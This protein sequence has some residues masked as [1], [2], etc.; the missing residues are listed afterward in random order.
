MP[1]IQYG[2]RMLN[3]Q[4]NNDFQISAPQCPT[5][6]TP[7]GNGDVLDIVVHRNVRLSDVTVSDILDSDHLPI[8]FHI[9]DHVSARDILAPVESHTD[10]KRFRS[11]ASDLISLRIQIDTAVDADRAA[12]NFAASI[13]SAYRLSTRK[14]TLLELNNELPE[15]DRFLHLKRGLRKLW[16]V[17]RD[18]SYKTAVRW[19]TK[20]I[21][22]MTWG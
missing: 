18:P 20:T 15:L 19:V 16:H 8:F 10:W 12:C 5:H 9:L 3:L 1:R 11:L 4:D 6:C 13:A 14:I 17:T 22:R 7:Q 2:M 21:S